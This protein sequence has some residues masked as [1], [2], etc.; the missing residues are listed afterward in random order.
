DD[1]MREIARGRVLLGGAG[2][3][4]GVASADAALATLNATR[5]RLDT[6]S[7]Q[8]ARAIASF[9]RLGRRDEVYNMGLALAQ[10]HIELLQHDEALDLAER[11]WRSDDNAP[12]RRLYRVAGSV[13]ARA[14]VDTGR[15]DEAGRILAIVDVDD[16]PH[17]NQWLDVR[18]TA[19]EL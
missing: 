16:G 17:D 11:I 13:Y 5:G 14:L 9:E 19:A 8:L 2:D 12:N 15:L 7:R 10:M 4:E 6:A 3:A 1:S 18:S